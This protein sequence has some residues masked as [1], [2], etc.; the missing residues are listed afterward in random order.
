VKYRTEVEKEDLSELGISSYGESFPWLLDEN[1]EIIAYNKPINLFNGVKLIS[2]F[3]SQ[4]FDVDKNL[5]SEVKITE[6]LEPFKNN[7]SVTVLDLF[8]HVS[9]IYKTDKDS[10]NLLVNKLTLDSASQRSSAEGVDYHIT[11]ENNTNIFSTIFNSSKPFGNYGDITLNQIG[12]YLRDLKWE[13]VLNKTE[14]TFNAIPIA[15]NFVGFSLVLRS[16]M[17]YVHNR[18]FEPNITLVKRRIEEATRNRQLAAFILIG[19][20][21]TLLFLKQSAISI[22]DMVSINVPVES[23]TKS[24]IEGNGSNIITTDSNL[25]LLLSRGWSNLNKKI[26]SWVK[27]VFRLLFIILLILKLLGFNNIIDVIYNTY[28]LKMYIYI[29]CSLAIIF[30][31]LNLYLLHKFSNPCF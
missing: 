25:F 11:S 13:A 22:K 24:L 27:I 16:F 28:Y 4:R 26:P 9:N 3:L 7:E 5:L 21:L 20:P 17:K 23:N 12:V 30:Q 31:L 18:P 10:L 14:F 1:G 6:L 19:A 2:N 8:N 15:M 29:S